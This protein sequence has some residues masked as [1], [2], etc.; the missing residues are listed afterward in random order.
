MKKPFLIFA[1]FAGGLATISAQTIGDGGDGDGDC[2]EVCWIVDM[3][4]CC[5]MPSGTTYYG[6]CN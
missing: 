1:I 6:R 4:I 2:P 5:K 3:V